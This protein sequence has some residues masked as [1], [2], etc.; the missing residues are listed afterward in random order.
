ME[1]IWNP[2]SGWVARQE[3]HE[4]TAHLHKMSTLIAY[5]CILS[6]IVDLKAHQAEPYQYKRRLLLLKAASQDENACTTA[7]M[8]HM[9]PTFLQHHLHRRCGC[10]TM[11]VG[12]TFLMQTVQ[13][14][15]VGN[16]QHQ[17]NNQHR[18]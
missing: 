3:H 1:Q 8:R 4:L 12:V 15:Q 6:F 17:E 2:D 5:V 9:T 18:C 14:V 7:M 11:V 10:C 16:L 13:Y